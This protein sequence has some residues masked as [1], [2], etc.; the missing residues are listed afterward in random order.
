MIKLVLERKKKP[1]Q[2]FPGGWKNSF[3]AFSISQVNM[4]SYN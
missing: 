4:C 3:E 1:K 2:L